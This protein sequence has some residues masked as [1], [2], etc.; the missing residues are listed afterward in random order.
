LLDGIWVELDEAG[1]RACV[2]TSMT[3]YAAT[4]EF[5]V[6]WAEVA[7]AAMDD[8]LGAPAAAL[9][10][11]AQAADRLGVRALTRAL[12]ASSVA[13]DAC[14]TLRGHWSREDYGALLRRRLLDA[15]AQE[16]YPRLLP[17]ALRAWG[18]EDEV[19]TGAI[20]SALQH[21]AAPSPKRPVA[22]DVDTLPEW[23]APTVVMEWGHFNPNGPTRQQLHLALARPGGPVAVVYAQH[24]PCC[25]AAEVIGVVEAADAAGRLRDVLV[26]WAASNG[27]ADLPI[28]G[29]L[30]HYVVVNEEV[31]PKALALEV[32]R[33]AHGAAVRDGQAPDSPAERIEE[34]RAMAADPWGESLR[35]ME[36]AFAEAE[37][38]RASGGELQPQ[39]AKPATAEAYAAWFDLVTS[40][41]IVAPILG[42]MGDAW[43]AALRLR[44]AASGD[45]D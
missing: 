10:R 6:R 7:A 8:E 2:D 33:R 24:H 22:L 31:V 28:C 16:R 37:A 13:E 36:Q 27:S 11:L 12:P 43:Q 21:G 14:V 23:P 39:R 17:Q 9:V 3:P 5:Y 20:A 34:T 1:Q 42:Q 19:F 29:C 32:F 44:A 15:A 25:P 40:T 30:P 41:A 35:Q 26:E 45:G 38:V 18:I 4:I